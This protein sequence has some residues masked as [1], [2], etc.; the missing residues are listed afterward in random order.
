MARSV[1]RGLRL[2]IL[3]PVVAGCTVLENRVPCPC[4][5]D[6]DYREVATGDRADMP[7]GVV[8]V[9][10]FAP[11][12]GW[13]QRHRLDDCPELEEVTVDKARIRVVGLVHDRPLRGF[14]DEGTEIRYEPGNQIDSL[15]VHTEEVNCTGEE[16]RAV[17]R[18]HKQFST[19]FIT[20]EEDGD[21]CRQYHLVIRGTTCGFDAADCG[22]LEG[23]YWYTVQEYDGA[24]R[25]SVRIPRQLRDDLV[26]EFWDKESRLKLFSSPLGLRIFD[27]GYDPAAEELPD[28]EFRIDF[29][30]ALVFLRIVDW[31]EV[32]VYG[33]YE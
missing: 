21:L 3:F 17:L 26:L 29:R 24:G 33:L 27:A 19:I 23:P 31:E 16:A 20:D 25:I 7:G 11:E 28:Y 9:K 5:L 1:F 13:T 32:R 10:L 22:A 4:Y 2:L 8:D 12:P 6:V 18:P 15:Y 30:R 14:L